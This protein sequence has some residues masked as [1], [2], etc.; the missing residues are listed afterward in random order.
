M[1][2]GGS[3]GPRR[4]SV[5]ETR[6]AGDGKL[7]RCP[8]GAWPVRRGNRG[9]RPLARACPRLISCGVPPGRGTKRRRQFPG[10]LIADS[11]T[12]ISSRLAN[13]L[14]WHARPVRPAS[15]PPQFVTAHSPCPKFPCQ[16][17]RCSPAA[18]LRAAAFPHH[19]LQPGTG[20]VPLLYYNCSKS[21]RAGRIFPGARLCAPSISRS[22]LAAWEASDSNG[23]LRGFGGR[24]GWSSA[25]TAALRGV[26]LRHSVFIVSRWFTR[27]FP[28]HGHG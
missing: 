24:C 28:L 14:P 11:A 19:P 9:R 1:I 16:T 21:S 5:A 23:C 18:E 2:G 12:A 8:A 10:G 26:R 13:I 20:R 4:R 17:R 3:I 22:R 7:L 6:G 25:D 15:K 27:R